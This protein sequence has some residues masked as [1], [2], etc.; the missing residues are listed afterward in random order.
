MIDTYR[1]AEYGNFRCLGHVAGVFRRRWLCWNSGQKKS[2]KMERSLAT[3]RLPLLLVCITL[4]TLFHG[5]G[6][7]SDKSTKN[8][9]R[10]PEADPA[11]AAKP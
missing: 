2:L 1:K 5:C 3:C 7:N 6:G 11:A 9:E 10:A 4:F 8:P